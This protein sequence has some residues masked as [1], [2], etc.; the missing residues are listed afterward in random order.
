MQS[1]NVWVFICWTGDGPQFD[2]VMFCNQHPG[3][4]LAACGMRNEE[5][6]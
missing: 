3:C 6:N 1:N 4:H 2:D 5:Q